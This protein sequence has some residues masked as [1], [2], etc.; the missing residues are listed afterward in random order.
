M[1]KNLEEMQLGNR[2]EC[3]DRKMLK[4]SKNL[5]PLW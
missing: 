5:L 2:R 1:A 3:I 4:K